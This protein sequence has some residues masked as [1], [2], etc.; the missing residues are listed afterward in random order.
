[1]TQAETRSGFLLGIDTGTSK[2]H[3]LITTCSGQVLGFGISG[4][5]NYE[6]VGCEGFKHAMRS[7]AA[8]A[9]AMAGIENDEIIGMGFGIS[10]Y[11][12][13]SERPMMVEAIK[14]LGIA[15]PFQFENDVTIGLIAGASEGWGVAVDAGTGNN[16]RGRDRLGRIG[17][18]T[19]NSVWHGEIGG[20]GEMVWLAQIAITHAW[21]Q[22]GPNTN[23]TQV[24]VEFAGVQSAFELIEGLA[25]GRIN[26]PPHLAQEIFRVAA[27]GDPVALQIINT[28]AHELALNVNAVIR[29]L[30]L[31][32]QTFDLV[33]IGSIFKAGE[34]F[35]KPFRETVL[36]F[37][38]EVNLVKLSVPPV[39]GAVLLANE[40]LGI[41]NQDLRQALIT[42]LSTIWVETG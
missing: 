35:L 38:P 34:L 28:S 21:T 14:S 24:L 15:C 23:L 13:P 11:D 9:L 27:D 36:A 6:V 40:T 7:A 26:L 19:G 5:G 18:I 29:Q 3:A 2:T 42:S 31:Q 17:R 33:L 41:A 1:L 30:N 25:T 10:G 39:M 4:C 32:N 8:D 20:G 22:R 37:A 12:W 16:V